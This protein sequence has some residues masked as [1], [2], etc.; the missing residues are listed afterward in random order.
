MRLYLDASAT[1]K[2]DGTNVG[3]DE[4]GVMYGRNLLIPDKTNSY[5]ST[6]IKCVRSC[7]NKLING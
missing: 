2:Y 6:P 3:K 4:H 1:Q 7:N 5:Q